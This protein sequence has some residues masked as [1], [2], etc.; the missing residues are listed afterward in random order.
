MT[1]NAR[2]LVDFGHTRPGIR[3]ADAGDV[4]WMFSSPELYDLLV[5][6][7]S[8][9]VRKYSRFVADSIANALL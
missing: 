8:W 7:R 6:R 1:A 3:V 5:Q 2:T 9:S 4:L